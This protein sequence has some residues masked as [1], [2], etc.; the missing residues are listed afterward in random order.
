MKQIFLASSFFELVCLSAG[1][2]SGVYDTTAA[3]ALLGTQGVEPSDVSSKDGSSRERIL[4]LS[5]NA[6]VLELSRPFSQTPGA[7]RLLARFDRVVDL[8]ASVHPSHPSTWS[9]AQNDLPMVEAHLRQTW[10]LGEDDVELVLESPQVNPAIALGRVFASATIRVHADGLMSYGPTRNQIPLANGQRMSTL[11]YLP[12]VPELEPRLLAEFGIVPEPLD[13]EAFRSV[14]REVGDSTASDLDAGLGDE[15]QGSPWAFA[16]GQYLAALGLITEEEETA[17]H[18]EMIR[19]AAARGFSRV[20]F[21]P[22]PA[23]PPAQ[24][25]PLFTAAEEDGITL[26]VLELPVLA[27][28]VIDRLRPGLIIGG[29]STALATAREVYGVPALT[30]GADMLL[31]AISPYQNSNRIPLTI[32]AEVC[33]GSERASQST[34]TQLKALV[35]AVSYCMAPDISRDLRS[36]AE[37]FLER[38]AET[39]RFSR[40]FKRKRLASLRLPGGDV[41][42][43]APRSFARR[44]GTLAVLAARRQGSR[45]V[46][47][48]KSRQRR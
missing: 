25:E 14:V 24:L 9:P 2:D 29:F 17:L 15:L 26:S 5:N 32:I 33:D 13:P 38:S 36:G 39:A 23:A 45:L 8:N 43:F 28:V 16:V 47:R 12:L 4:L 21:K 6:A 7:D 18:V 20:V 41:E 35:E 42:K 46:N 31:E 22:H 3:P 1:I 27:E 48:A 34:A 19:Q 40:Y 30:V 37:D 44:T 11:H 10:D